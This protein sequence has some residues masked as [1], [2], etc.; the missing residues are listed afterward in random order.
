[1]T[2]RLGEPTKRLPIT[3]ARLHPA[4]VND[5][6]AMRALLAKPKQRREVQVADPELLEV[7]DQLAKLIEAKAAA[8]LQAVGGPW[9]TIDR[10]ANL[11][12]RSWLE[13]GRGVN[14]GAS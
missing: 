1:S 12:R 6:I 5:V 7:R 4:V 10:R 8:Q 11:A 3:K 13:G 14:H 2:S 9:Q